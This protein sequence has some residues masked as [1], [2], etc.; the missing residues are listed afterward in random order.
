MSNKAGYT[1]RVP[2]CI[3]FFSSLFVLSWIF[4]SSFFP[5]I[6]F[7]F[8][9]NVHLYFFFFVTSFANSL[10]SPAIF[11]GILF[12]FSPASTASYSALSF[13]FFWSNYFSSE[14]LS[15]LEHNLFPFFS[16]M[17]KS[18]FIYSLELKTSKIL[19]LIKNK[20]PEFHNCFMMRQIFSPF[21]PTFFKQHSYL[22]FS[23]WKFLPPPCTKHFLLLSLFLSFYFFLA[24]L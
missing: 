1:G 15:F 8:F 16:V 19:W 18:F 7:P 10:S 23:L 11:M 3:S 17:G 13:H 24:F 20:P 14:K 21:P 22:F 9:Q 5:P 2:F 6:F 12:L 4:L